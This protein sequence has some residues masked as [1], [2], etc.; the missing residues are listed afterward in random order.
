[1]SYLSNCAQRGAQEVPEEKLSIGAFFFLRTLNPGIV[2]PSNSGVLEEALSGT[3]FRAAV[4]ISKVLQNLA[5]NVMF[6]GKEPHMSRF[7]DFISSNIER[8]QQFF[9]A[10]AARG[11]LAAS[12]DG[13]EMPATKPQDALTKL[14]QLRDFLE[15]YHAK[16]EQS[17]EMQ[18]NPLQLLVVQSSLSSAVQALSKYSLQAAKKTGAGSAKKS[19]S[20]ASSAA[21]VKRRRRHANH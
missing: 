16:I 8:L 1:M 17:P 21:T 18:E 15:R 14:H 10:L 6:G 5:N 4:L 19:A 20:S 9:T 3:A 13:A 2:S 12:L 7:N 11:E